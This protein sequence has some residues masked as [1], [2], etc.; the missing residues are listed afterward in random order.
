M[1][2]QLSKW[3]TTVHVCM[4]VILHENL[5]YHCTQWYISLWFY[6][7]QLTASSVFLIRY[8]GCPVTDI[9]TEGRWVTVHRLH[10]LTRTCH[11]GICSL[12]AVYIFRVDFTFI[13]SWAT[14]YN[15]DFVYECSSWL[16]KQ[17]KG[18]AWHSNTNY[19]IFCVDVMELP[20]SGTISIM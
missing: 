2:D 4:V 1:V 20:Q 8:T 6:S 18:I 17:D 7:Q 11:T 15:K 10:C 9:N 16:F 14:F 19:V 3:Y 13:F 12:T 5:I